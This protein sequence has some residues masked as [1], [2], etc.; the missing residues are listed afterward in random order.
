[1]L[2]VGEK[3]QAAGTAPCATAWTATS[4]RA[5]AEVVAG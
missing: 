1:M 3:E 4:G 5:R 2:V